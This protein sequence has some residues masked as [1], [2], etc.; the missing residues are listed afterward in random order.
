VNIDFA[1]YLFTK[2]FLAFALVI[3]QLRF[4]HVFNLGGKLAFYTG[5]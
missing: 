5:F 1:L 4:D 2:S 3:V